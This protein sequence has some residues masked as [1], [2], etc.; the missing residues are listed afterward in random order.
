VIEETF[1]GL[2]FVS[3]QMGYHLDPPI[4]SSRRKAIPVTAMSRPEVAIY[5]GTGPRIAAAPGA[6]V[7]DESVPGYQAQLAGHSIG[8]TFGRATE[9]LNLASPIRL[10]HSV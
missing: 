7:G 6:G 4:S 2:R 10:Q 5:A 8:K 1:A 3:N 9:F